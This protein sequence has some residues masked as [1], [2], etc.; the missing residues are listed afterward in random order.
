MAGA[1]GVNSPGLV[2]ET[3]DRRNNRRIGDEA[4]FTS[5]WIELAL[6]IIEVHGIPE[7]I[8]AFQG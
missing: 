8:G 2:A 6:E 7:A 5:S 1:S 3:N 4:S